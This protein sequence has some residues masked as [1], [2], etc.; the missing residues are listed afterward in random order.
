V[1]IGIT[2]SIPI[3]LQTYGSTWNE[4]AIY[5]FAFWPFNL[6]LLWAPIIDSVFIKH[7]GRRKT[8]TYIT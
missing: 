4:Q 7:F 1:I 6:K 8:C 3:L 2:V 5:S